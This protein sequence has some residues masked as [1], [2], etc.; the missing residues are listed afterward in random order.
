MIETRRR[1]DEE[2][3]RLPVRFYRQ[4]FCYLCLLF[5]FFAFF[6]GSSPAQNLDALAERIRSGNAEQKR[7]ALFEIRNLK[8]EAASEIALSALKDSDE[9][10]RASAAFAVIYLPPEKAL[11]ALLPLLDDKAEIVRRET[12]YALGKIQNP[13]AVAPLIG[14]YQKD[15]IAE[16]RAA[17]VVAL[18]EIGDASAVSLLTGIL[19]AKPVEDE[20]FL[21]RSAARAIGQIAQIIQ[22]GKA[23][24]LTPENFLPEKY[25]EIETPKFR[26]LAEEF[27]VFGEAVTVL[28]KVLQNRNETDDARREAAFAL[29]AIGDRQAIPILQ[30]NLGSKDYFLAEI[31][32][33]ALRKI[34]IY[35]K[36]K[37]S[38]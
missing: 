37:N 6:A 28:I 31:C 4:F 14:L 22:T 15:K 27:P 29:G 36:D 24:V 33:E 19:Q 9:M 35:S 34:S 16:V 26:R 18:G 7:Q 20:E 38:E 12:A 23:R 5:A 25:K 10:V 17:A 2:T 8:S 13:K 21:R 30:A 3:R 1:G 32:K 11:T